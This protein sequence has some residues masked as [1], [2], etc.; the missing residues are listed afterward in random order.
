MACHRCLLYPETCSFQNEFLALHTTDLAER[1]YEPLSVAIY[2]WACPS[3]SWELSR[4]SKYY[5]VEAT[6]FY[7]R[8]LHSEVPFKGASWNL[9]RLLPSCG[10]RYSRLKRYQGKQLSLPSQRRCWDNKR[11]LVSFYLQSLAA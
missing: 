6:Y 9:K 10:E 1:C 11:L 5:G 3:T 4:G 8:C 7:Q 2:T